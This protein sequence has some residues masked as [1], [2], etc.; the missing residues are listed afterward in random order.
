MFDIHV[1]PGASLHVSTVD[2]EEIRKETTH[3]KGKVDGISKVLDE[4]KQLLSIPTILVDIRSRILAVQDEVASNTREIAKLRTQQEKTEDLMAA[5]F[6]DVSGSLQA[7]NDL[8]N[9]LS[10]TVDQVVTNES[11]QLTLIQQLKDQIAAGGAITQE[12]LDQLAASSSQRVAALT[13]VRDTLLPIAVDASNPVPPT[14]DIPP[15]DNGGDVTPTPQTQAR[16]N[17]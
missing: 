8:T 5:N 17:K 9:T 6:E 4:L 7:L 1:Q 14:P 3:T 16:R 2:S 15:V 11:N 12:Q 13:V 10:S